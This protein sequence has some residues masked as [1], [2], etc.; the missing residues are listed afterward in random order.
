MGEPE[1]SE[2]ICGADEEL[3]EDDDAED[4][5][6]MD[7]AVSGYGSGFR[8]CKEIV[9]AC[10]RDIGLTDDQIAALMGALDKGPQE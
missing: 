6:Y 7:G 1:D 2:P 3:V 9:A 8:R 4:E 10:A 5:A